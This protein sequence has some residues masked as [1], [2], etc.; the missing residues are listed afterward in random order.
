MLRREGQVANA[1]GDDA[2]RLEDKLFLLPPIELDDLGRFGAAPLEKLPH[3][4][5]YDPHCL[6]REERDYCSVEVVKMVV[7]DNH[8]V[9]VDVFEYSLK[10][11]W[12]RSVES[13]RRKERGYRL[14]SKNRI[15]QDVEGPRC[16]D[17]CR[18]T[19]PDRGTL[20]IL[21]SE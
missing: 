7:R 8:D 14:N 10:R 13:S 4:L 1:A 17:K 5:W 15:R 20:M 2:A 21:M 16:D 19:D 3:A 12:Q 18:L 11:C 6:L 9:N